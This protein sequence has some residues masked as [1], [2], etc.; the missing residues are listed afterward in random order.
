M[1]KDVERFG[2]LTGTFTLLDMFM[3][4]GLSFILSSIVGYIYKSTHRGISYSQSYVHTLVIMGTT[5]ALIM[6]IVGSNIA[7]A[8][9]LVGALSIVRFRNAMKETRDIGFIFMAMAVGM[10]V[11]TRFYMLAVFATLLMSVFVIILYKFNLFAKVINERILRVQMPVDRQYEQVLEEPFRK[12]LDDYRL[13]SVETVRA[14]VL[15]EVIYSVTLKKKQEPKDLLESIRKFNDNQ[16]VSLIL[17]Q[18]EIDF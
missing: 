18:Q 10:A 13:I 3:V 2:D 15:L 14:G 7:R 5:I 9:A 16:K 11:G 8:F 4:M 1:L 12:Y 17:G 6:L